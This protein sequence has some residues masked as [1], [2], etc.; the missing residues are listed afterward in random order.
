MDLAHQ[1]LK[2]LKETIN[3][4]NLKAKKSLGQHFLLD[5]HINQQIVST[6]GNLTG[7]NVVEI[8]PGPGGLTRAI[9]SSP[10]KTVTAIEMDR[11]AVPLLQELKHIYAERF[12]LIEGDAL[13]TD[14]TQLCQAPRQIIANLPYNVGTILL[15]NWLKQ[16]QKW[17]KLTLMFQ[18]EVAERICAQPNS[19]HYG[20]L[21]V[22]SQWIADCS[23]VKKLP[24]GAFTPAPKVYS[25]VVQIV[26][27]AVQPTQQLFQSMEKITRTAF[28]QR[29]K[30]LKG[31]LKT[32]NGERLLSTARIDGSRRAETLTLDEFDRLAHAYQRNCDEK[33]CSA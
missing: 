11:R 15:L 10:A 24:P 23:I 28:G 14:L 4:Y 8:G 17:Q 32:I 7:K 21:S 19:K 2:T 5:P 31:A 25:A 20:R 13:T 26:P 18:L 12:Q 27:H 9:L 16:A 3:S 22:I 6:A 29:R 1:N 30:M 33:S